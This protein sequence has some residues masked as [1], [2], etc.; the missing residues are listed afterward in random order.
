[1]A[2]QPDTPTSGA[3][4]RRWQ[5]PRDASAHLPPAIAQARFPALSARLLEHA[6]RIQA[7]RARGEILDAA[8]AM[9]AVPTVMQEIWSTSGELE[10]FALH[11]AMQI[12]T[13][14]ELLGEHTRALSPDDS[15]AVAPRDTF[16]WLHLA[17]ECLLRTHEDNQ[18]L[19]S[20]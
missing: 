18:R 1:M 4:L 16:D 19:H 2:S 9:S 12:E 11:Q 8:C 3:P 14:T 13:L 15:P 6:A 5:A 20:N 7:E 10:T 17:L